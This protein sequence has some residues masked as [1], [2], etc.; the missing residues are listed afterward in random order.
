[1][2]LSSRVFAFIFV[3]LVLLI[4]G[5]AGYLVFLNKNKKT[6]PSSATKSSVKP[7]TASQKRQYDLISTH[8][9]YRDYLPMKYD[10]QKDKFYIDMPA[11]NWVYALGRMGLKFSSWMTMSSWTQDTI[12]SM[13]LDGKLS[14]TVSE[15]NT[16]KILNGKRYMSFTL[17]GKKGTKSEFVENENYL[18]IAKFVKIVDGKEVP[19]DWEKEL[20]DGD[21]ITMEAKNDLTKA[22]DDPQ[23]F[24]EAKFTKL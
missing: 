1:M 5:E 14:G 19:M 16:N 23:F 18:R 20:K 9:T 7:Y 24:L 11:I 8:P 15:L 10:E 22:T 12:E 2:S 4:V 6:A 21:K 17:I 13:I 3:V